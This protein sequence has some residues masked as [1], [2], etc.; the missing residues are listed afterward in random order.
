[1]RTVF[2]PKKSTRINYA[3]VLTFCLLLSLNLKAMQVF[4]TRP[5]G[6]TI[7]L[8]VDPSDRIFN[9]KSQIT[10]KESL[11]ETQQRLYFSGVLLNDNYT[12]ADYSIYNESVLTLA[13]EI[14]Y[15]DLAATG[16]NNGTSW[17]N[18]YT[19]LQS[20]LNAAVTGGQIWVAKGV[21]YA[22]SSFQLK[23]GVGVYGGF[24]GSETLLSERDWETNKTILSGDIGHNDVNT[25]G[26]FIA[27]T[28]A[29][30]MGINVDHVV[31][32]PTGLNSST[33]LD[34]FIVTAGIG[35]TYFGGGGIV[36]DNSSPTYANL[37]I[38]GNQ[39]TS[40]GGGML[41]VQASPILINVRF[42][43]NRTTG[44]S[45]NGY[46]GGM[47]NLTG[48]N[49]NLKNVV[50]NNN[51]AYH[52]G[53]M[54]F[55]SGGTVTLDSVT[56]TNNSASGSYGGGIYFNNGNPIVT[57]T[58]STFTA[59]HANYGGGI[60]YYGSSAGGTLTIDNTIFSSNTANSGDGRGGGLF[61]WYPTVNINNTSFIG[62]SALKGGGV[63]VL[64]GTLN[65]SNSI[66]KGNL[67]TDVYGGGG[68]LLTTA[69]G[70]IT[71]VTFNGNKAAN[72]GALSLEPMSSSQLT[73]KNCIL[74][75]DYPNEIFNYSDIFTATY[76]NI[77]QGSGVYTG[78]G[79]IN[80]NP[81]FLEPANPMNA[82]TTQGDLRLYGNS[83]CLDAGNNS[84]NLYSSDIRG[85]A[86][87]Q[88]STID[89]GAYEW[90]Q[91]IDPAVIIYVKQDAI[92][93]NDGTSWQN[94][95]TSLQTAL[96]S[97][98][99]NEYIFIA[100]GTYKPSS[101]YSL[102]NTPR[103]YHFELINNVGIYGGFAGTET[104]ISQR[105]D[106]GY[107]GAN[108]TILS[109]DIGTVGL[110]ADNCLHVVYN[111]SSGITNTAVL[112]GVTI[113]GGNAN[114][115]AV[116]D[117]K[118]GGAIY[119]PY[120]SPT[121]S[122]VIITG[123]YANY[124]GGAFNMSSSAKYNNCLFFNNNAAYG[125][126]VMNYSS[127]SLVFN[128]CT[129]YGNTATTHGGGVDNWSSSLSYNNSIF[130]GNTA[131]TGNQIYGYG[132][133]TVTLNYSCFSNSSNDIATETGSSVQTT[134]NNSTSN[135]LFVN[136]TSNDFRLY[137]NS[138]CVN[139]GNNSYNT[140][141]SDIRGKT[142]IQNTTIDMGAYEW[143]SSVDPFGS[144]VVAGATLIV[145]ANSTY[146]NVIV[147]PDGHLTLENG[148][149]L[150]TT[151]D[152]TIESNATGTGSFIQNGTLTVGDSIKVQNYLP[153]NTNSGWYVSSPLTNA[154]YTTFNGSNGLFLYDSPNA[155]WAP[156]TG[157]NLTPMKGYV[158]KFGTG[159]GT[160]NKTLEFS[161]N[162]GALNNTSV[163]SGT[164]YRTGFNNGNF[165]W[166]L[167]GNP[168]PSAID[169]DVIVGVDNQT[170]INNNH[171][172]PT[173]YLRKANGSVATYIANGVGTNDG[174]KYIA[175][176]QAFWAQVFG[177]AGNPTGTGSFVITNGACTHQSTQILK[178]LN[179]DGLSLKVDREGNTDEMIVQFK[180]NA[181]EEFDGA[182]DA[183]KL[184]STND[185][186]PQIFSIL[187]TNEELAINTYPELTSNRTVALGFNTQVSGMFSLTT[188]DL[189]AFNNNISIIL[190]DRYDNIFTNLRQQNTYVFTSG[191]ANTDDR[192]V[193]HFNT[194][195][196]NNSNGTV[197]LNEANIYTYEN[198][199]Y[200]SNVMDNNSTLTI[201]N[202]LGQEVLSQRLANYTLNKV[203]TNLATGHYVVKLTGTD[204]SKVQK[205]I[206]Q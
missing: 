164:L 7:T 113:T 32:A 178:S 8:E 188:S 3:V 189:S 66:F 200:I 193:L 118:R 162:T 103:Y 167:I 139:T 22:T 16:S 58:N 25:D 50:F 135:P 79:N 205:V 157:G 153:D 18:A 187:S 130:W 141:S 6:G 47:Y 86:R 64:L 78:T 184:F 138:P 136:L 144:L 40:Y 62:N 39:A 14:T 13:L 100:R 120:N 84:Y 45:T 82:P 181:T 57:I 192:F 48:G 183:A 122:N 97:V 177:N 36:N 147:K 173:I 24:T 44:T 176:M 163:S 171:V 95:F 4:V 43:G 61:T 111:P 28:W 92:G 31:L 38:I 159:T 101:A 77:Q 70:T 98:T 201:Y 96:N 52:G 158:S 99:A 9:L 186:H 29:D 148:N 69:T 129:F 72:G 160:N 169:W 190:E 56:F 68:L 145:S 155:A 17:A 116:A 154:S 117:E 152:F 149:T 112:D 121:I 46:G 21:Y 35:N 146:D 170:F 140:L 60:C 30:I 195:S 108:E 156:V 131:A 19:S 81:I 115:G 126:A 34:G 151:G 185:Y 12:I 83:P 165:G 54:G 11:P 198:T 204:F 127:T 27:E 110:S 206:V 89:M 137:G 59:N 15:V 133:S 41:N 168:Y 85:E 125:G 67:S 73:A 51:S 150:T 37:I 71:N 132:T 197:T 142:R 174:T 194:V 75:G 166:N 91:G 90:T 63:N 26:N 128:N 191:I 196:S 10:D 124:G 143:T 49:P 94:A 20:A 1:M 74:W 2:P 33:R 93:T 80:I 179:P 134:N 175:P 107:G 87:I 53:G 106:F 199:I 109:G 42:E 65:M 180:A 104:S 182:Y 203:N 172:N 119:M 102:T 202:V 23:N 161:T 105:T 55:N 114:N 5:W 76:S 123:N 88:N